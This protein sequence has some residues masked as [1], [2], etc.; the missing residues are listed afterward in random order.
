MA[1]FIAVVALRDTRVHISHS[2]SSD[3][4]AEVKQVVD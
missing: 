3:I 4:S 2:N 1:L